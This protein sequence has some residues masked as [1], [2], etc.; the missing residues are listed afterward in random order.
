MSVPASASHRDF[1]LSRG[2][3]SAVLFAVRQD[4]FDCRR[5]A[6][7]PSDDAT[8]AARRRGILSVSARPARSCAL[9]Q[10]IVTAD[11]FG[12]APEV[13]EAVE[14]AHRHGVLT[15]ASLMVSAPAASDAVSRARRLPTLKVG[16]HL[17]LVEGWP[18]SDPSAVPD[19]VD[20]AG[21]LRTDMFGLGVAIFTVPKIRRQMTA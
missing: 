21:K 11:D 16:L 4:C 20:A 7:E 15:A 19:L 8:S 9:K 5:N 12:L 17:V 14:R 6:G 1:R 18:A 13:N 2:D 10:L 3:V